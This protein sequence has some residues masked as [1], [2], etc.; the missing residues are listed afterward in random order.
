[1]R[2][3]KAAALPGAM[4]LTKIPDSSSA[5]RKH[6]VRLGEEEDRRGWGLTGGFVPYVSSD[7]DTQPLRVL[8]QFHIKDLHLAGFCVRR[9]WQGHLWRVRLQERAGDQLNEGSKEVDAKWTRR[10]PR[11]THR[12]HGGT[13]LAN[14]HIVWPHN[15]ATIT[16]EVLCSRGIESD[17]ALVEE[18]QV[19]VQGVGGDDRWV[20]GDRFLETPSHNQP[21]VRPRLTKHSGYLL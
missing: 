14:G 18:V 6:Q 2:P 5:G 19:L 4:L 7:G 21:H 3:S 20:A 15:D 16:L 9:G 12:R 8:H 10:G 13:E 1:M 17:E 11:D